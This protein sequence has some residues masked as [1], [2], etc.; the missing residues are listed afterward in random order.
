[1]YP[2]LLVNAGSGGG[3]AQASIMQ[4]ARELK[5]DFHTA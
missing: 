2:F 4:A 1:M 3:H 5:V